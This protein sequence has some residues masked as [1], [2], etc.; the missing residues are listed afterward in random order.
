MDAVLFQSHLLAIAT[1]QIHVLA[2]IAFVYVDRST[3]KI[4]LANQINRTARN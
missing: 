4:H 2:V 3:N 1:E